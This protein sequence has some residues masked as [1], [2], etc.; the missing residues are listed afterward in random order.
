M[1]ARDLVAALADGSALSGSA[2]AARFGVTRTMVWKRI[3]ELRAAGLDIDAAAGQGYRLAAPVE[4]LD[5]DAIRAAMRPDAAARCGDVAI[6]W[7]IDS[8]SS[9]LLRRAA[10]APD[11]AVCLAEQQT[12]GRGRR[13]RAWQSPP[14]CNVY[15]SLV[16][17]FDRG[18][19]GLVGL[20]LAVG[21][22]VAQALEDCGARG[23]GLKWPN[24][25][26]ADGRK[27]AGILVE[28]G[29]EFLGP[30]HA[31]IGIGV[32]VRL[33]DAARAAIDQAATDLA[34]ASS[35]PTGRNRVVARLLECLVDRLDAFE[36][37]GFAACRAD[38]ARYDVLRDV[39]LVATDARG[40]HRGI[41]AG[42]DERG[43]LRVRDG[44]AVALFDSAE[45]TV[46]RE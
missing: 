23:I 34:S 45:V 3:E 4:L 24:D 39:P 40:A 9:E 10:N 12:A 44:D 35:A 33:P 43:A 25:V 8:T 2:L 31:V 15:L 16:K 14:A 26:L 17:R 30:C 11:L 18:M 21:V 19:A 28:L 22:A 32:N 27:L 1:H 37:D 6:H 41:G 20:S 29:G 36:R 42:V 46:R 5:A 13:G 38:Y 7:Q